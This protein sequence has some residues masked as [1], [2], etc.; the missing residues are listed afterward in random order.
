MLAGRGATALVV[1]GHDGLDE[2]TTAVPTDVWTATPEGVRKTT[3]DTARFGLART[4][5]GDLAGGDASYNAKVVRS[6]AEG[7]PGPVLD[8][9]LA[10]AAGTLTARNRAG[11][12]GAFEDVF[13]ADLGQA[14]TAV[15]SGAAARLLDQWIALAAELA[16]PR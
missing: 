8:A 15:S 11:N 16:S 13:A 7:E 6:A 1:R 12:A 5:P 2:I 14:R 3:F 9:V 10:N 4:R